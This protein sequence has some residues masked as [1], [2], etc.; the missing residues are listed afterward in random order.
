MEQLKRLS[1]S[2]HWKIHLISFAVG[3]VIG[4]TSSQFSEDVNFG[5]M[6]GFGLM[7]VVF[8]WQIL[9]L[10]C[11]HCGY[12]FHLRRPLSNYCPDCGEK[13]N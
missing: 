1:L 2:T 7:I 10:K 12:H 5:M 4:L 6:I 13:I 8:V 11:P 3:V 9:F